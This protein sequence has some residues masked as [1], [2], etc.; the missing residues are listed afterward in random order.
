MTI[1]KGM[2]VDWE[3]AGALLAATDDEIQAEFFKAFLKEMGSWK[4]QQARE[5]QLCFI[6]AKLTDEER[7][8]MAYLTNCE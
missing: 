3:Y 4:T 8:L 7:E 2:L 5:T 1:S 6:R